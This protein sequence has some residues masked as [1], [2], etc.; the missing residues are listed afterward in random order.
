MTKKELF[1]A[2][3]NIKLSIMS[4]EQVESMKD[5]FSSKNEVELTDE[6]IEQLVKDK[7]WSDVKSLQEMRDV[8]AK[9][10]IVRNS[11]IFEI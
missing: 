10:N 1:E 4:K 11:L 6:L 9:W 2:S 8:G 5:F 3:N 7:K